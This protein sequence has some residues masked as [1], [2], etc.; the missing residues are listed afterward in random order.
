MNTFAAYVG[1]MQRMRANT[2]NSLYSINEH[3]GFEAYCYGKIRLFK[4]KSSLIVALID[5]AIFFQ[6]NLISDYISNRF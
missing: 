5:F 1:R 4:K 3:Q 6:L 2:L